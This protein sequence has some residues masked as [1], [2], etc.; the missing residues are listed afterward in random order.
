MNTN[1]LKDYKK[2]LKLSPL[3]RDI[4][5]GQML[6]DGH[7]ES[8]TKGRTWRLLVEQSKEKHGD[9]LMH[10][11]EVFKPFVLKG[12]YQRGGNLKFRT[13]TFDSFRFYGKMF[14]RDASLP[15]QTGRK[16]IKIVPKNIFKHLND[17]I[18]AY[19]YMDDG[20][21]KGAGRSGKRLHTEGFTREDV[22]RLCE[23]LNRLGIAT[24]I[25]K[26]TRAGYN[27]TYLLNITAAGDKVL[28]ERIRPYIHPSMLYKL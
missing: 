17:R 23:A 9:Y 15:V 13:I 3:Q 16:F 6:G 19:W 4:I 27:T 11:Y 18:L 1:E 22:E 8:L 14:Y 10:L 24:T 26:Q 2:T 7:L 21:R 28:T 12:P 25:N 20:A 5:M